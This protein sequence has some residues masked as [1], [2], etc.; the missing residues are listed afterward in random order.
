MKLSDKK[1]AT[2]LIMM[3]KIHFVRYIE[4]RFKLSPNCLNTE[5]TLNSTL[6]CQEIQNTQVVSRLSAHWGYQ[7]YREDLY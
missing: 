5:T 6:I 4:N 1:K 3:N 7:L 2:G